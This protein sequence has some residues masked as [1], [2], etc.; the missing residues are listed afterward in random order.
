MKKSVK[1]VVFCPI[2][3]FILQSCTKPKQYSEIP[4]IA[5]ESVFV[6]PIDSIDALG[7]RNKAIQITFKLTDGDGDIGLQAS[8]TVGPFHRDSLYYYNLKAKMYKII[9]GKK[10]LV[11]FNAPIDHRTPYIEMI[12]QNKNLKAS[13]KVDY[14]FPFYSG[15]TLAYDTILYEIFIYDRKLHKSN[16][17]E[18]PIIPLNS[19]G[20]VY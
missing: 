18:T 17:I 12:G 15:D 13:L 20:Y 11:I 19:S 3:A 8:D 16:E 6:N 14:L 1:F 10:Q 7:S 4:E 5:F 2:A 9:N